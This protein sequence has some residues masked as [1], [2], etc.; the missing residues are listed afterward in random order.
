MT[1]IQLANGRG[2]AKIDDS[3]AP[4][5]LEYRWCLQPPTKAGCTPYVTAMVD[6]RK[7]SLHRFLIQEGER[8]DH[9]DGDGLN[10]Q[11]GNL[12]VCTHAENLRNT[13]PY[14]GKRYKG[15]THR[16]RS[17]NWEAY[18]QHPSGRQLHLGKFSTEEEAARAYDRA[19]TELFGEFARLNLPHEHVPEQMCFDFGP[20]KTWLRCD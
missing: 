10:N 13:R 2:T 14:K 9:I 11:R 17:G 12:R 4:R 19:A 7:V 3:D 18:I 15:V 20:S 8:V 6:R 16:Q 5:V 1:E